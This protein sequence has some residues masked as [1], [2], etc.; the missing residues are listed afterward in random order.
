MLLV[1]WAV[2]VAAGNAAPDLETGLCRWKPATE[3]SASRRFYNSWFRFLPY[4]AADHQSKY[5]QSCNFSHA[6]MHRGPAQATEES[7]QV[8]LDGRAVRASGESI[9]QGT[10][11]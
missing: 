9:V 6:K 4:R 5:D 3:P 1:S 10:D 11:L 2:P 7:I 8:G